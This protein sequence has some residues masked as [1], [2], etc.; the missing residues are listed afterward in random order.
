MLAHVFSMPEALALF[1]EQML[2]K[3]TQQARKQEKLTNRRQKSV[4]LLP[5]LSTKCV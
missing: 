1:L 4:H 3:K 5:E 2:F